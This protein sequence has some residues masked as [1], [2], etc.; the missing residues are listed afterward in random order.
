MVKVQA[1]AP[2]QDGWLLRKF[3]NSDKAVKVFKIVRVSG[4]SCLLLGCVWCAYYAFVG[5]YDLSALFVALSAI[6][7]VCMRMV[8][9]ADLR[10][11]PWWPMVC[12]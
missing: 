10:R 2:G 9:Q 7:L 3:P 8:R 5:R 11:A 4:I 6:G 12:S 1:A